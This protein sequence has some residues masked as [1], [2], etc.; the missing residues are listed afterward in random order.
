MKI[1]K[2]K[3]LFVVLRLLGRG[4]QAP[5]RVFWVGVLAIV[6]FLA[7]YVAKA[8]VGFQLKP[9]DYMIAFL[10][11]LPVIVLLF[12]KIALDEFIKID[13]AKGKSSLDKSWEA[14]DEQERIINARRRR[15]A[16]KEVA[17]PR[18]QEDPPRRL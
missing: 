1:I 9:N 16:L 5:F 2:Q 3:V 6:A 10:F 14:L 7:P 13:P 18:G 8:V 4:Q 12:S 15:Q 17:S 11:T